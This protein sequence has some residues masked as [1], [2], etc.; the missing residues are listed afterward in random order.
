MSSSSFLSPVPDVSRIILHLH[1]QGAHLARSIDYVQSHFLESE[2][3]PILFP[4]FLDHINHLF[5]AKVVQDIPTIT[6]YPTKSGRH[7]INTT[8]IYSYPRTA[9]SYSQLLPFIASFKTSLYDNYKRLSIEDTLSRNLV[10]NSLEYFTADRH[11]RS[12]LE[13]QVGLQ[14][15]SIYFNTLKTLLLLQP[16]LFI[17]SHINYIYYTAPL[18]ACMDLGIPVL[19]L[20]GGY[21]ETILIRHMTQ[22]LYSPA[23]IRC[24]IFNSKLQSLRSSM[25]QVYPTRSYDSLP[26]VSESSALIISKQHSIAALEANRLIIVN[27]QVISEI[28]HTFCSLSRGDLM[29]NRFSTLSTVLSL[30]SLLT[31]ADV[32]LRVHPDSD[33]YPGELELVDALCRRIN[34]PL[35]NVLRSHD[36]GRLESI[37]K[38]SSYFPEILNLGG[39]ATN[40]L[41]A[42]GVIAYSVGKC[43]LP[44]SCNCF[45]LDTLD[46]LQ[47]YIQHPLQ[48]CSRKPSPI[49]RQDCHS[50]LALFRRSLVRSMPIESRLDECDEYFHFA[51]PKR[52]SLDLSSFLQKASSLN[53]FQSTGV[54]ESPDSSLSIALF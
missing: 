34:F 38:N 26:S 54:V 15:D 44:S 51:N 48:Y 13:A 46:S 12:V 1:P 18:M 9:P 36:D 32:Y 7:S 39:N 53:L 27:H 23:N 17:L 19:L 25:P 10:C 21:K 33:R 47:H 31:D 11:E 2:L 22:P 20:H 6:H 28:A 43:F 49:Q 14:H 40:E 42:H 8:S 29:Q 35:S 30:L 3:I 45:I 5:S 24:N 4:T 50:F 41:L 16:S 52:Q 37:I